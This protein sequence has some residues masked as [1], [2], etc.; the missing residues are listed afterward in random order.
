MIHGGSD[1]VHLAALKEQAHDAQKYVKAFLSKP[2][3]RGLIVGDAKEETTLFWYLPAGGGAPLFQREFKK[4]SPEARE[5]YVEVSRRA[6]II[7][8]TVRATNSKHCGFLVLDELDIIQDPRIVGEA[9]NI[10]SPIRHEDGSFVDPLTVYISTRKTAFGAVQKAIDDAPQT[11]LQVDHFSILDVTER[12]PETRHRPDLPRLQVYR[13]DETLRVVDPP[14]YEG[15]DPKTKSRYV[16]DEA[17]HGC[18]SNCKIFASC[19]GQLAT[20]P[21]VGND[22]FLV[23][24]LSHVVKK[25]SG[26]AVDYV[27][28][29]LLCHKP[30]SV[31]LIFGHLISAQH[32]LRPAEVYRKITGLVPSQGDLMTKADLVD[33][34]RTTDVSFG[35]GQDYG[36]GHDFA[37]T[38]GFQFGAWAFVLRSIAAPGLD[39]GQKLEYSEP[40]RHM[41]PQ[42]YGDTEDPGMI[43][44]FRKHKWRMKHWSKLKGS[45]KTGIDIVKDK[46]MPPT[47][48]PELFF[49]FDE[50]DDEMIQFVQKLKEHAWKLDSQGR[51]TDIPSEINKDAADSLRYWIM[52]EFP[53][54][55]GGLR[56]AGMSS[57]DPA[58]FQAPSF[59]PALGGPSKE[60]QDV[61]RGLL[62]ADPSHRPRTKDGRPGKKGRLRFL[63]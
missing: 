62:G 17:Y 8:A 38:V 40:L 47:E 54:A 61:L 27:R 34:L 19:K 44:Y 50:Q 13:S 15:F 11:G 41:D 2:D 55:R 23:K 51:P 39:P 63:G 35:G 29:Q 31:G 30:S 26:Q 48:E 37:F 45:V 9:R 53:N 20:R 22:S 36:F 52:N 32:V 16:K 10:P 18:I 46:L 33:Y 6:N 5:G 42:V 25:I 28:S 1:V 57:R 14:T 4:L 60:M 7:A 24:P 43:E 56:V 49:V 12:C 59:E 58:P 21:E 3:L